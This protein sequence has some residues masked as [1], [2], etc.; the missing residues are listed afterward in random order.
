MSIPMHHNP[1]P[2]DCWNIRGSQDGPC[3][4]VIGGTHGDELVGVE[5]VRSLL[6]IFDIEG[7]ASGEYPSSDICGNVFFLFGN[8]EAIALRQRSASGGKDLNRFFHQDTLNQPARDSD[9]CD[10]TR[11]RQLAPILAKADFVFD[12]HGTSN[13][14]PPFVCFGQDSD[15]HRRLYRLLPVEYVLTDPSNIL[16][17]DEG[18]LRRGTTDSY[19][20]EHGGVALCYE[21]GKEDDVSISDIVLRDVLRLLKEVGTIAPE[22]ANLRLQE[23]GVF[24][25]VSKQVFALAH[26][27]QAT[28]SDFTYAPGMNVGW[29]EVKKHQLVGTYA[30]GTEECISEDGMLVFPK[31][32]DKIR[33]GKNLYYLAMKI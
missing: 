14:S 32:A 6:R 26:S 1:I 30:D 15:R 27:V 3:V 23:T 28:S 31:S 5:V 18:M 9:S 19:V 13:E 17:T 11:A 12:L 25:S 33:A 24:Y 4:V 10:L 2:S 16:A 21:T 8:P 7:R 22:S 29:Q 20:E